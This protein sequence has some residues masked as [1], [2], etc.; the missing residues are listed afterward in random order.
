MR[1][2]AAIQESF[3]A[4]TT[5]D[6][7]QLLATLS[8]QIPD[9]EYVTRRLHDGEA[10]SIGRNDS[11][12]LRLNNDGVAALHC[13]VSADNGLIRI[14]D[15]YSTSGTLVDGRPIQDEEVLKDCEI[16]V[17]AST[18][19]LQ[20]Q[21]LPA[22]QSG[23]NNRHQHESTS[24]AHSDSGS[25]AVP[26]VPVE[27][28]LWSSAKEETDDDENLED[29]QSGNPLA[30]I[31]DEREVPVEFTME[32][33]RQSATVQSLLGEL[34]DA[35]EE[36][37]ELRRRLEQ[38]SIPI[39]NSPAPD[40]YQDEMIELLKAEVLALQEEL[41]AQTALSPHDFQIETAARSAA[42]ET[43]ELPGRAEVEKLVTRLEELLV[44]LGHKDDQIQF[45]QDLILT[46]ETANQAEQE[47]R[48]QLTAWL[49]EFEARFTQ[50]SDEWK[51]KNDTLCSRVAQL[52]AE[53]DSARTALAADSSVAKSEA[54]KS[55]NDSLREQVLR[56]EVIID[57]LQSEITELKEELAI[58]QRSSTKE[59]EIRLARERAEI[60]RM[61]HD[62]EV[63]IQNTAPLL[64]GGAST[65]D[66]GHSADLRVRE[67]REQLRSEGVTGPAPKSLSTRLLELWNKLG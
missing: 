14:K 33:T 13:I 67:I 54:I 40:P 31:P 7:Q 49:G 17:G 45:M 30:E 21:V 8:V 9:G 19:S 57:E 4:E 42:E 11:V 50:L 47:E 27:N 6:P 63:R 1:Y 38:R 37:A 53:R 20:Y 15:C 36:I 2:S 28:S 66:R 43:T 32:S 48:E 55:M 56:Q 39:S 18:L 25:P 5:P 26:A 65:S 60:A 59:E 61:R 62:L 64:S 41:S 35:H 51:A 3:A 16:Q 58:A 46:A 52:T 29:A 12:D 44:E 10:I 23:H 24:Y 22:T 34:E